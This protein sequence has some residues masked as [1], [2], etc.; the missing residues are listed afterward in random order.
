[1]EDLTISGVTLID[2]G[3]Y[4]SEGSD[5]KTGYQY[6]LSIGGKGQAGVRCF[7]SSSLTVMCLVF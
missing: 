2:I 3:V 1:M 7:E 6:Q 5:Y 4:G